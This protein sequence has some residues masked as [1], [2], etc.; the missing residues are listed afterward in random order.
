VASFAL[1][2]L[3]GLVVSLAASRR[4]L[5]PVR[6]TA[7][8]GAL[9]SAAPTATAAAVDAA[10]VDGGTTD[11]G[12]G[13]GGAASCSIADRGRGNYGDWQRLPIGRM[14]VPQPAPT[15]DYD[16][17]IHFHGGAAARKLLAPLQLGLSSPR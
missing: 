10:V 3:S 8:A 4:G 11:S 13:G 14:I 9:G 2:L 6:A 1:V 17:L 7:A 16:L 5:P 15:G 12:A